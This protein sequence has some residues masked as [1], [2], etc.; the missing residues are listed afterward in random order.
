MSK[1]DSTEVF[2]LFSRAEAECLTCGRWSTAA[3]GLERQPWEKMFDFALG[4]DD[5]SVHLLHRQHWP[6]IDGNPKLPRPESRMRWNVLRFHLITIRNNLNVD[7]RDWNRTKVNLCWRL[8]IW[9][10]PKDL[11]NI[12]VP[13]HSLWREV[14]IVDDCGAFTT[15]LLPSSPTYQFV[16]VYTYWIVYCSTSLL[17]KDKRRKPNSKR[18]K[19]KCLF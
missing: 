4:I 13:F 12:T 2:S 19:D 11:D 17:R 6:R 1:F 5:G 9:M 7:D 16:K 3:G 8:L 14:E 18:F 15:V 10:R